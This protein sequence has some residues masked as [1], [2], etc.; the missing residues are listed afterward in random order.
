MIN[1]I[2]DA[3]RGSLR[4][5]FMICS[6]LCLAVAK[7][8]FY[9]KISEEDATTILTELQATRVQAVA[10]KPLQKALLIEIGKRPD[11]TQSALAKELKKNQP[12][13]SRAIKAPHTSGRVRQAKQGT[14]VT[15]R[16]APEIQLALSHG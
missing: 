16:L 2:Y 9:G 14:S 10:K 5:T 7:T 1:K 11:I 3:A 8:P 12:A 13:I 15:Y 6:K 4:D